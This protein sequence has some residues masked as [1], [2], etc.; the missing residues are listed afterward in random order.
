VQTSY[1]I[2]RDTTPP[3]TCLQQVL[4]HFLV[5]PTDYPILAACPT[6]DTLVPGFSI[7]FG[8][9]QS[10]MMLFQFCIRTQRS[11]ILKAE[12]Y[13][14]YDAGIQIAPSSFDGGSNEC[15]EWYSTM[16][17]DS[18]TSS[19]RLI[20]NGA[21]ALAPGQHKIELYYQAR[22]STDTQQIQFGERFMWLRLL[23]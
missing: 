11:A 3:Q 8:L 13:K 6:V 20:V 23:G 5:R 17:G 14:L 1:R 22:V 9:D 10:C 4:D 19:N 15:H 7:S 2:G 12:K 16:S 21:R 18:S